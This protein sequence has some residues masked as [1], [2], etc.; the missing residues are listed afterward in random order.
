MA[1]VCIHCGTIIYDQG[2][3]CPNCE[4]NPYQCSDQCSEEKHLVSYNEII[5]FLKTEKW[6]NKKKKK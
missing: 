4:M 6:E 5:R 1:W 2:D 3:K